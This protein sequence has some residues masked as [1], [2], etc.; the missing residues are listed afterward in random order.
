MKKDKFY[1][2]RVKILGGPGCGKTTRLLKVL[3]TYLDNELL[4]PDQALMVC[5]CQCY[6]G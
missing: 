2:E 6:C 1:K 4:A 5:F 3:K